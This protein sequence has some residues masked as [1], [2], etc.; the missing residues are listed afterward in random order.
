MNADFFYR[1][2]ESRAET[3]MKYRHSFPKP[4][5]QKIPTITDRD[6]YYLK[7]AETSS[8]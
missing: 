5:K 7:D 8:G 6:L 3:P 4:I 2:R 1:L